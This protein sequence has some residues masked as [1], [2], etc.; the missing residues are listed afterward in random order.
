MQ[1]FTVAVP[2]DVLTDLRDR[3]SRTRWPEEFPSGWDYGTEPAYL[4][5]L[6]GYWERDYD[7]RHWERELNRW[8]QIITEIDTAVG[9]ERV[10]A[11]HARS[12]HEDA[13]PL[14]ITHGWPGSIFEFWKVIGPLVDP[15]AFGGSAGDAFHVVCPSMGGYGFSGGTRHRG[16][17]CAT[18][19]EVNDA[20]MQALGYERYGCQGGDWGAIVS[21][22][23]GMHHPDRLAGVHLNMV[24]PTPAEEHLASLTAEET[25][26]LTAMGSF[27]EH[28]TGYQRIQGTRPMTLSYGLSDS[29][30]G[31]AG[32]IVEKFRVWSDCGGDVESVFTRDELLTNIS[33]YWV[34]NTIGSSV[35]MYYETFKLGPALIPSPDHRIEVPVGVA[36]F[37]KEI[38]Q[39][40]RRFAERVMNVV[41]WTEHDRGGHFAALE[42]PEDFV[43]DVRAFFRPL[44]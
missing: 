33:I 18:Q 2:D 32:W 9:P 19:A 3:L 35:R 20:L 4:R 24:P 26:R 15:T 16:F 1:P 30:A 12:P 25:E 29:P 42:R 34:T 11:V 23:M 8:P 27:Q 28:E 43:A 22:Q 44:R 37:P 7:W 40:S 14:V 17:N 13:L 5:D 31:L 6:C 41:H 21:M 38:M 39:S 36:V 10:H